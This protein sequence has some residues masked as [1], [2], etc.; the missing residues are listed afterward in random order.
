MS[1]T[2]PSPASGSSR[3][4]GRWLAVINVVLTL[5]L[6]VLV[7]KWRAENVQLDESRAR[8]SVASAARTLAQAVDGDVARIDGVLRS[9]VAAFERGG[10]QGLAPDGPLAAELADLR[11]GVPDAAVVLVADAEGTV[12]LGRAPDAPP[13]N[14]AGHDFFVAARSADASSLPIVSKPWVG[15]S[16]AKW[17][18]SI[19]RPLRTPDGQFAG[20][21]H[22]TL[23]SE[24]L[25]RRLASVPL[26]QDGVVALRTADMALVA[27]VTPEGLSNEGLGSAQVSPGLK[28]AVAARPNGGDLVSRSVRDGV[29]RAVAYQRVPGVPLYVIV[30]QGTGEFTAD[31]AIAAPAAGGLLPIRPG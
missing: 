26:G 29:A 18:I 27:R 30:G 21:V 16:G 23:G 20:T 1:T 8:E 9:A 17:G 25:G 11:A 15:R 13:L 24:Y 19:A 12:R 31:V 10:L 2:T 14:L 7:V 22:A 5:A 6:T 4:R 3:D 28:A